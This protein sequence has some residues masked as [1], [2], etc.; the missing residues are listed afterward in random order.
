MNLAALYFDIKDLMQRHIG[1]RVTETG[2]GRS[3]VIAI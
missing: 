3:V 2:V 1:R